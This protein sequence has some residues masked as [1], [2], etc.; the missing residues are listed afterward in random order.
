[1]LLA[2][3]EIREMQLSRIMGRLVCGC[4]ANGLLDKALTKG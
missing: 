4:A 2:C 1:M 3:G